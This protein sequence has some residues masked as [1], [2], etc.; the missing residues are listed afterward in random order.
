[1]AR[2]PKSRGGDGFLNGRLLIAMPTMTD[3]RFEKSVILVCHHTPETAMG[4]VVNKAIGGMNF[5]TLLRQLHIETPIGRARDLTVHSGGPVETSRGFVL[6]SADYGLADSTL[7]VTPQIALTATMD[8]LKAL[9]SGGGPQRAFFA[10]GYAGWGAGQLEAE[11]L[12]N[13]WLIGE[14]DDEI[15]FGRGLEA[16]WTLALARLGVDPAMVSD[17]SGHA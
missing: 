13:A 14:P 3:P 7:P 8:V 2:K 6:H 10:L 4:L 11:L 1:M 17:E 5:E 9:G 12:E 15:V 16:K